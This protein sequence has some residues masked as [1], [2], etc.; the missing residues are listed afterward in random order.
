MKS[1]DIIK[2]TK[3]YMDK[4]VRGIC[5]TW[6]ITNMKKINPIEQKFSFHRKVQIQKIALFIT[7]KNVHMWMHLEGI[8]TRWELPSTRSYFLRRENVDHKKKH[9]GTLLG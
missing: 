9:K 1:L 8:I 2:A 3:N 7:A 6:Q 5:H 4:K